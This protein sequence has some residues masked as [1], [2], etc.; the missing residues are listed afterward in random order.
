MKWFFGGICALILVVVIRTQGDSKA[1][2]EHK[3]AVSA[4]TKT[5]SEQEL[6][7]ENIRLRE[8]IIELNKEVAQLKHLANGINSSQQGIATAQA[9]GEPMEPENVQEKIQDFNNFLAKDNAITALKTSFDNEI[10]DSSWANIYQH[11]L[12]DFL[13]KSF[14]DV[15][16]QYIECRSKRCKITVPVSDQQRFSELSQEL[17]QKIL[18]NKDGISKKI[19]IEPTEND[20]TLSFY[21]TRNDEVSFLQ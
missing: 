12:E 8:Q 18:N 5:N 6:Q 9:T 13:K 3:P 15:I 2:S 10:I 20:G 7:A 17:I 1:T 14:T 11:E 21:L 4:I 16:P 19:M